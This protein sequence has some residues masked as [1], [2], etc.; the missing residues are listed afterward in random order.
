MTSAGRDDTSQLEARLKWLEDDRAVLSTL[1]RYGHSIDYG[2][3]QDWVDCFTEDGV[4]ELMSRME[5]F[6]SARYAGREA[7]AA[8]IARSPKPPAK[9]R[10]HVL[11]EPVISLDGGLA[12]VQS[13]YMTLH[14]DKGVPL[15]SAFG[16]YH[17]TLV[18]C[19]DG[20]WRFKERIADIEARTPS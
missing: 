2:L 18:K 8:F 7:L 4:F 6:Q 16:R 12:R 9:Y 10:K 17:D 3:E 1:Y 5:S 11:V 14:E 15:I 19:P 20:R 13:Y